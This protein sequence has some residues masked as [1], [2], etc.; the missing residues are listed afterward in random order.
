MGLWSKSV[1]ASRT[2][3]D[4]SSIGCCLVRQAH[5][6]SATYR[7]SSFGFGFPAFGGINDNELR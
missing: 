4:E 1:Y 2:L 7:K 3:R 6:K 5:Y